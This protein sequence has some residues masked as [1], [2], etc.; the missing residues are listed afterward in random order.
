MHNRIEKAWDYWKGL[1][2]SF[3]RNYGRQL[4]HIFGRI[5]VRK[6]CP[7]FMIMLTQSQ[8][9]NYI[10][11]AQLRDSNREVLRKVESNY[12]KRVGCAEVIFDFC[13][14]C[15]MCNKRTKGE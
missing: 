10:Y 15:P 14:E 8:H 2:H 5:G 11:K 12:D 1:L 4:H 9:D 3:P 6:C 7:A 13:L